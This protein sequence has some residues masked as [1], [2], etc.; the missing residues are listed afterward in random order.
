MLGEIRFLDQSTGSL[1]GSPDT[2]L[3][4]LV[5]LT[6]SHDRAVGP[7][8]LPCTVKR[9][10]QQEALQLHDPARVVLD[11]GNRFG[12]PDHAAEYRTGVGDA[13]ATPTLPCVASGRART[14][15]I[16]VVEST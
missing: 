12:L 13:E 9:A 14:S 5:E 1:E 7:V 16:R 15:A 10:V 8:P 11:L 4:A 2:S 3:P 6:G